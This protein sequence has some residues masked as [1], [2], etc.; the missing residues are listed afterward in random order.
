MKRV[1]QRVVFATLVLV[2]A[3]AGAAVAAG[4]IT[5][6]DIKNN[7]ITGKDVKN[8]S[9]TRKDFKGSVRGPRGFTGP[10]GIQGIQGP[11]GLTGPAGPTALDYEF[12]TLTVAAGA[13]DFDAAVC[14]TGYFPTGGGAISDDETN[15]DVTIAE[16]GP[17]FDDSGNPVG[18]LAVARNAGAVSHD[19]VITVSCVTPTHVTGLSAAAAKA[20]AA[21]QR[22]GR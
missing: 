13:T 8:G 11:R 3:I 12:T 5:G 22:L 2:V 20:A 6:K 19:V 4:T 14:P 21:A 7:T 18:W 15:A 17:A 10:Q 16:N 1:S 9:L